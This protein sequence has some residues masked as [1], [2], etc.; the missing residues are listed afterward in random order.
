LGKIQTW[1]RALAT[2]VR[3][4]EKSTSTTVPGRD[5]GVQAFGAKGLSTEITRKSPAAAET[6]S[7]VEGRHS[8]RGPDDVIVRVEATP[9]KPIRSWPAGSRQP[10]HEQRRKLSEGIC[11]PSDRHRPKGAG[12]RTACHDS[13]GRKSHGSGKMEG[14][15][16]VVAEGLRRLQRHPR[17]AL[18]KTIA[19]PLGGECIPSIACLNVAQ[20]HGSLPAGAT[21]AGWCFPASSIR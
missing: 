21:G 9:I 8:T 17:L 4:C 7:L 6:T 18:A 15:G 19:G 11:R 13:A 10:E 12:G 14:A 5:D 20:V 1:T 2:G 3:Q 16:T